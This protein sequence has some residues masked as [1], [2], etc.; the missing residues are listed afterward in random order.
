MI[1]FIEGIDDYSYSKY[2]AIK[3][4]NANYLKIFELLFNS[5][6]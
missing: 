3:K 1:Y 6:F 5:D 4:K 2:V